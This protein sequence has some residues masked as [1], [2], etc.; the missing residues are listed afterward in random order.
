[1]QK[2]HLT[3]E[4]IKERLEA[5]PTI[6]TEKIPEIEEKIPEIEQKIPTVVKEKIPEI[7]E[8][9]VDQTYNAESENAQSGKAVAEAVAAMVNSAPEALDTLNELATALGNDPNFATTIAQEIGEKQDKLTQGNNVKIENNTISADILYTNEDALL[10]DIGGIKASEHT[11]GFNNVPVTDLLTEL[12]YPYTKPVINSFSLNPAA[13]VKEMNVE[14]NVTSATT[15]ITKKSKA[16]ESV[17]LYKNDTLLET[18]NP[19]ITSAGTTVTFSINEKLDGSTNTSYQVKVTEKNGST[20]SSNEQT[21]T[22]VYP[23]YYGVISKDMV[24]SIT[25]DLI[26]GLTK[27]V[28]AK[29]TKTYT[30]TTS[31]EQCALIAYPADYGDLIVKDQNGFSQDWDNQEVY[32][33]SIKYYVC[34]S[35]PAAATDFRYTFS[36]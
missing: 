3:A 31:S 34:T 15:K 12:L 5:I 11:T 6:L 2:L 9:I 28:K 13:G 23:Y 14:L 25:T 19:E 36:Y 21:Y 20:I 33:N 17:S 18:K 7:K 22:F 1:M 24:K 32:I 10:N 30:Y 4:E 26:T 27:D 35:D 29:G 8:E 16:I